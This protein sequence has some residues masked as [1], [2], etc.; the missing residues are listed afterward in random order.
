VVLG[1]NRKNTK[2][3]FTFD[4]QLFQAVSYVILFTF[5]LLGVNR[6]KFT[7]YYVILFTPT[8]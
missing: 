4:G 8:M 5:T 2:F 1:V 3:L 6:Q 7:G